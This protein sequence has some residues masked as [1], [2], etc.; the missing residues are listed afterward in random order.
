MRSSWAGRAVRVVE[1]GGEHA[2]EP[3]SLVYQRGGLDGARSGCGCDS[4]VR[5][6]RGIGV[7]VG[8]HCLFAGSGGPSA[9]GLLVVD[10][11]EVVG[12]L[13]AASQGV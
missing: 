11:G 4:S 6:E 12:E 2:A 10:G 13:V 1:V 5:G 3:A 8:D 9:W 7:D